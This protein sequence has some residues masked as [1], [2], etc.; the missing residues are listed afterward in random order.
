MTPGT[1]THTGVVPQVFVVWVILHI[2]TNLPPTNLF[3]VSKYKPVLYLCIDK[4]EPWGRGVSFFFIFTVHWDLNCSTDKVAYCVIKTSNLPNPGV[5]YHRPSSRPPYKWLGLLEVGQW[6]VSQQ[7]DWAFNV[8]HYVKFHC[9]GS[10]YGRRCSVASSVGSSFLLAFSRTVV[11]I[12]FTRSAPQA[13]LPNCRDRVKYWLP[14]L[15]PYIANRNIDQLVTLWSAVGS[16]MWVI[17]LMTNFKVKSH[18]V[19]P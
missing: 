9:G 13:R 16:N 15:P 3:T 12:F 14:S 17:I 8:Y 6:A 2:G 10:S 11:D 7:T 5:W 19:P 1:G 18:Y 4:S